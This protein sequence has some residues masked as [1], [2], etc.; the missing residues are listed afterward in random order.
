MKKRLILL[1][2]LALAVLLTACGSSKGGEDSAHPYSWKEKLDGSVQLT[3]NN[4]PEDGYSWLVD[5][6]ECGLVITRE[7]DGTGQKAV[8]SLTGEE[9]SDGAVVFSCQRDSAPFDVSY[10]LTVTLSA[11][12]KGGVEV[13]A[14]EYRQFPSSGSAGEEGKA[15][16]IWY[17]AEDGSR[18]IYLDSSDGTYEWDAM[19]YDRAVLSVDGPDYGETGVTFGLM[20]IAAGETDLLLYDLKQDY[21]F[22][23]TVS[24]A[25]DLSVDVTGCEEGEY[26]IASDQIPGM[27]DAAA[28]VGDLTFPEGI[29]VLHCE[30]GNWYGGEENDYVQLQLQADGKKWSLLVTRKYS[31]ADLIEMC[32]GASGD[33]TRTDVS[34]GDIPAVL[35]GTGTE[36]TLFW[37]D[38]QGRSLIFGAFSGEEPTQEELLHAA[39]SLSGEGA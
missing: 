33:V 10:Q 25:E 28:L 21:G 34:V 13:T 9:F 16:C 19:G 23:L 35:C 20:G 14:A 22:R 29:S 31:A 32:Y 3:I 6:S 2:A 7:D 26:E 4:A 36:Q 39:Q 12:Q 17:T 24:V 38:S 5:G 27:E 37:T 1:T 15:G 30:V 18:E 8:F 11:T